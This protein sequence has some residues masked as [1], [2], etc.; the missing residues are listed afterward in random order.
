MA[1]LDKKFT[2]SNHSADKSM[3][4]LSGMQRPLEALTS[5]CQAHPGELQTNYCSNSKCLI[6]LCP[7]CIELHLEEHKR[8]QLFPEI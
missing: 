3:L 8:S 7:D 4:S 6:P 5:T 1:F 2:K